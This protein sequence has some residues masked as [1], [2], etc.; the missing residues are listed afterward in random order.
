MSNTGPAALGFWDTLYS[1]IETFFSFLL[2]PIS[3]RPS[4]APALAL[5]TPS[6]SPTPM[7]PTAHASAG[8]PTASATFAASASPMGSPP[9]DGAGALA[10]YSTPAPTATPSP[11]APMATADLDPLFERCPGNQVRVSGHRIMAAAPEAGQALLNDSLADGGGMP[12][13]PAT[14]ENSGLITYEAPPVEQSINLSEV[15]ST[16]SSPYQA[17]SSVLLGTGD[18]IVNTTTQGVSGILRAGA[19]LANQATL[20]SAL[21][22]LMK[23]GAEIVEENPLTTTLVVATAAVATVGCVAY[24]K[25]FLPGFKKNQAHTLPTPEENVQKGKEDEKDT[26]RATVN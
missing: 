25:G 6:A 1:G 5:P 8:T 17:V 10:L 2:A 26:S 3:Y 23:N 14:P 13:M 12:A 15:N 16:W 19:S 9:P 11:A 22:E 7:S 24:K 20:T 4:P 18:F 21:A